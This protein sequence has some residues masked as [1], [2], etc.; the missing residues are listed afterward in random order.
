[1]SES[2]KNEFIKSMKFIGE[3]QSAFTVTYM[4]W[5]KNIFCV[6]GCLHTFGL[7]F[8]WKKSQS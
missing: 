5:D 4:F 8:F 7:F 3:N 6:T 1:M 2:L